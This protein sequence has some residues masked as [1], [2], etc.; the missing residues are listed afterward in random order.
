MRASICAYSANRLPPETNVIS[1]VRVL[2]VASTDR[3]TSAESSCWGLC[4]SAGHFPLALGHESRPTRGL[5]AFVL[6]LPRCLQIS[7]V[8]LGD[9]ITYRGH[10]CLVMELYDGSLSRVGVGRDEAQR[11]GNCAPAVTSPHH[12]VPDE[13]LLGPSPSCLEHR[14]RHQKGGSRRRS[15]IPAEW[16]NSVL[17]GAREWGRGGD[18][19]A[20]VPPS[21]YAHVSSKEGREDRRAAG[22]PPGTGC[23]IH[24]IRHVAFQLVS[25]LLLLHN[26][27]LI[28]ADIRP[29][30]VFLKIVGDRKEIG[31]GVCLE[32]FMRGR[33]GATETERL[34]VNL[35]DFGNAIH[36]SE[37]SLYYGDFEFQTLAYRAPE[38]GM[39]PRL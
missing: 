27:G 7:V 17:M 14:I 28:H 6:P 13:A 19:E 3:S 16:N 31:H 15:D 26:H 37:A 36:K 10:F 33:P 24:V 2:S 23:P 39:S 9:A 30:N 11:K 25:A 5:S 21:S 18:A 29:E 38:V 4:R 12:A 22:S 8:R 34:T 32:D 35:G 20:P 1:A